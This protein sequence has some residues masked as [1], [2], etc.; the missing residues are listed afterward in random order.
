MKS[1]FFS[2][3]GIPSAAQQDAARR[4][5]QGRISGFPGGPEPE[6]ENPMGDIGTVSDFLIN[7]DDVPQEQQDALLQKMG[8]TPRDWAA[9]R[10]RYMQARNEGMN[11]EDAE[12]YLFS[13]FDGY[14]PE[15]GIWDGEVMPAPGP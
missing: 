8:I 7:F 14:D 1:P 6:V 5:D 12:A 10:N 2:A 15:R 9:A 13:L 4:A 3:G 11:E